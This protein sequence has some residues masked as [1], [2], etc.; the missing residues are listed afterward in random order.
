[1]T[2]GLDRFPK[3]ERFAVYRA[4]H[5][6]LMHEDAEYRWHC[7]SYIIRIVCFAVLLPIAGWIAAVYLAFRQQ[8]FQN[9]RIGNVLQT[10][11]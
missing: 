2:P 4:T 10:V 9:R 8:E 6:R 3:G 11:A 1:M 5:K 7:N